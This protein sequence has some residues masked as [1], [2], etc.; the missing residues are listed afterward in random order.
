MSDWNKIMT[1]QFNQLPGELRKILMPK[2]FVPDNG[3][4]NPIV[5]SAVLASELMNAPFHN[6]SNDDSYSQMLMLDYLLVDD[7]IQT[8]F[9]DAKLLEE[10]SQT[11]PP[12]DIL[13]SEIK[14][15][16]RT[17]TFA[18]PLSFMVKYVGVEVPFL[19]VGLVDEGEYTC[20]K[21]EQ[22][23]VSTGNPKLPRI[24][25]QGSKI[26]VGWR[27]MGKVSVIYAAVTP[28]SRSLKEAEGCTQF[29]DYSEM[30]AVDNP[31][32][33]EDVTPDQVLTPEQDRVLAVKM[34]HLAFCL[35]LA[36]TAVPSLYEQSSKQLRAPTSK[37]ERSIDALWSPNYIGRKHYASRP[38]GG[39]HA[40]PRAHWRR[41]HF[42]KY[43]TGPKPWT[44]TTPKVVHWIP[45]QLINLLDE[46]RTVL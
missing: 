43:N 44:E 23:A 33:R 34:R 38:L 25:N 32:F 5:H 4:G 46:V 15:P 24:E 26:A 20:K 6:R 18:L 31:D 37:G 2:R 8:Y 7:E 35:L 19:T 36:A 21:F 11:D 30:A 9:V 22:F 12:D 45:R 29:S 27:L 40:S 41:A 13:L 16:H 14:W 28:T 3:Y 17:M 39:T 42:N 10:L 1:E